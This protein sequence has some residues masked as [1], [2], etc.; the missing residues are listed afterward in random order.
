MG[1]RFTGG[2]TGRLPF[3]EGLNNVQ[4][5]N[6][7]AES[8]GV[9][10]ERLEKTATQSNQGT[11]VG[12]MERA[13]KGDVQAMFLIYA[14]HIDLPDSNNLVRPALTKTFTVVQEIYK[15]APNN[16]Y[17]DV[18]LPAAT[19]GEWVG[20]YGHRWI[21]PAPQCFPKRRARTLENQQLT[22]A[23]P[24]PSRQVR[25]QC[26]GAKR[27]QPRR[28]CL[29]NVRAFSLGNL[30]DDIV[31]VR[32]AAVQVTDPQSG[33]LQGRDQDAEWL[34]RE[35]FLCQFLHPPPQIPERPGDIVR[36]DSGHQELSNDLKVATRGAGNARQSGKQLLIG[37]LPVFVKQ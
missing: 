33:L 32:V 16:L 17:A 2:L 34:R 28:E 25:V 8:W 6:W 5:R 23:V 22:Q 36:I 26:A 15:Q 29:D 1:E 3:N 31:K 21:G 13:L 7:I 12:M 35:T 10:K 14:T 24:C 11:A 4:H 18:I 30:L 19:W 37:S 20:G 9:S 27:R